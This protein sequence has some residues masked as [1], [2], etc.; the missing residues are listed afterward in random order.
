[1]EE[2]EL[3]ERLGFIATRTSPPLHDPEELTAAVVERHLARRRRERA[4]GAVAAAVAVIVVAVPVVVSRTGQDSGPAAP[5]PSS[6]VYTTPTRG[7]LSDEAF[8]VDGVRRLPWTDGPAGADVPEPPLDTRHVVFAGE[9]PRAR[10]VLVAGADPRAPLPPDDDGDGRRDL[11]RL[12]SVAIAWFTGPRD[13]AAEDMRVYGEPRMVDADEPA[14][15]LAHTEPYRSSR[16]SHWIVVGAPGDQVE[17]SWSRQFT[18]DGEIFREFGPIDTVDGVASGGAGQVDASINRALRYRVVRGGTEFTGLPETEPRPDFVPPRVDLARL[19]PAPP[20]APGDAA[21][22]SAIDTLISHLG[23]WAEIFDFTV[24]WAGDLPTASGGARVTVLAAQYDDWGVYLTGALGR[25]NA[26][27]V[28]AGTCGSEIRPSDTPVD[29]MVVVLR[30]G[31]A[32]GAENA[33]TDNLV[34]VAPAG[35]TTARALDDR[36]EPIASYPLVDG[37]AVVPIPADLASVAVIGADGEMID[38]RAPMGQVDWGD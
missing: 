27:Q 9:S 34:V 21:V 31:S 22:A 18:P 10:W 32:D 15:V 11:D 13:A 25:D 1:M 20:P 33:P 17:D 3:R 14:A 26:G 38:D 5:A 12:D 8:F 7:N 2:T 6:A 24:L 35:A 19:R 23:V 29:E 4:L 16:V 36:G 37:V 28:S 30:C